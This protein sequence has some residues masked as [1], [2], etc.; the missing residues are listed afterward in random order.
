MKRYVNEVRF[1]IIRSPILNHSYELIEMLH[2]RWA[3]A[4][5]KDNFSGHHL[6]KEVGFYL[7]VAKNDNEKSKRT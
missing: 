7:D 1:R 5:A 2:N 3:L 4:H 6:Q